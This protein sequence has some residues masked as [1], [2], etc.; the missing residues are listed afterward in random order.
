MPGVIFPGAQAGDAVVGV[1]GSKITFSPIVGHFILG[2]G[3]TGPSK[4]PAKVWAQ[5]PGWGRA[6]GGGQNNNL[7]SKSGIPG[8]ASPIGGGM[9]GNANIPGF[10]SPIGQGLFGS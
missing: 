5:A 4:K 1:G 8:F 2:G 10:G 3:S 7:G 6:G 9:F